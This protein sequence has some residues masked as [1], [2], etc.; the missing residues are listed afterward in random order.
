MKLSQ[1]VKLA[2]KDGKSERHAFPAMCE[3]VHLRQV[4]FL[5]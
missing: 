2:G 4:L 5:G 3:K 1:K